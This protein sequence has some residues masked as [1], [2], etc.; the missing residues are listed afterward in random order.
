M[1]DLNWDLLIT[2]H[3]YSKNQILRP[4]ETHRTEYGLNLL[5]N[6]LKWP[7]IATKCPFT[8]NPLPPKQKKPVSLQ[9]R[10]WPLLCLVLNYRMVRSSLKMIRSCCFLIFANTYFSLYYC[11]SYLTLEIYSIK[12]TSLFEYPHS[13]S[14]QATTLTK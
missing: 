5:L 13:L 10:N 7:F 12:S 14:Y 8:V 3:G 2:P 6:P 9:K 1:F 11:K 4:W